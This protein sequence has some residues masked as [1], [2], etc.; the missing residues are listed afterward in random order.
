MATINTVG[1]LAKYLV[2]NGWKLFEKRVDETRVF[3]KDGKPGKVTIAGKDSDP[4]GPKARQSAL[5]QAGLTT[6]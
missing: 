5:A 4:I 6:P 1:D 3:K 2:D